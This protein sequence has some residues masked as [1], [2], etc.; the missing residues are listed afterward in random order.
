MYTT[1]N[2]SVLSL[3]HQQIEL[4]INR[5]LNSKVTKI[6]K[7]R[8]WQGQCWQQLIH[9]ITCCI[10]RFLL[11]N[12][13]FPLDSVSLLFLAVLF[14]VQYSIQSRQSIRNNVLNLT[15]LPKCFPKAFLIACDIKLWKSHSIHKSNHPKSE[16]SPGQTSSRRLLASRLSV[17]APRLVC[18]QN[19]CKIYKVR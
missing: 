19:Y 6:E 9:T 7:P 12:M 15:G 14:A 5:P 2:M 4:A 18:L 3:G 1:T 8:W 17:T 11:L 10:K 16:V 13:H